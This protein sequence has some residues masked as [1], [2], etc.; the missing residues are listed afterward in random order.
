MNDFKGLLSCYAQ[1]KQQMMR[2]IVDSHL[3][4]TSVWL[5]AVNEALVRL[6]TASSVNHLTLV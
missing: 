1:K 2:V 5:L 4:D 6:E 3:T